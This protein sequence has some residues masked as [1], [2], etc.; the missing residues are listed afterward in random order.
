V[1]AFETVA[2]GILDAVND[3]KRL[4]RTG[5]LLAGIAVPESIADHSYAT[6]VAALVLACEINRDP[7]A[8]GLESAVD[9]EVVLRTALLHDLPESLITDLPHRATRMFTQA[10]KHN[11][12]E[13]ALRM[14]LAESA[15]AETHVSLWSAYQRPRHVWCTMPTNL[16][17]CIRRCAMNKAARVGWTNF[18]MG[19]LGTFRLPRPLLNAYLLGVGSA[20]DF[21]LS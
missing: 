1:G 15:D 21:N 4:P 19:I 9:V 5:W 16:N 18:G 12:E 14:I 2:I 8:Q 13:A 17:C 3:L 7:S 11:A 20:P 10:T 6:A